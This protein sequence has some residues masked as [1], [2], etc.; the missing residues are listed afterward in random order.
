M[1]RKQE[2]A[3]FTENSIFAT[4]FRE[5]LRI[6]GE[7]P[8]SLARRITNG[9]KEHIYDHPITQQSLQTYYRGQSTPKTEVLTTLCK[10]LN[11]SAD[12]LLGL[13]KSEIF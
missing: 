1:H 13:Q 11:V 9:Y 2:L 12:Y 8:T 7:T 5:I 10:A 6:R 3:V 4:N